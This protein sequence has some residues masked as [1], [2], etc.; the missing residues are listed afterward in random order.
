[1]EREEGRGEGG[2]GKMCTPARFRGEIRGLPGC[3]PLM[4]TTQQK[5]AGALFGFVEQPWPH[6]FPSPKASF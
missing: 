4:V 5:A 3:P 6:P 1:M 2:E